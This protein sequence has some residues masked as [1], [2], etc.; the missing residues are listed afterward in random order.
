MNT[1]QAMRDGF[2]ELERRGELCECYGAY[3]NDGVLHPHY[4]EYHRKI[5][6]A[7]RIKFGYVKYERCFERECDALDRQ[8]IILHLMKREDTRAKVVKVGRFW[9]VLASWGVLRTDGWAA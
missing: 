5:A 8:H 1:D 2:R 6:M 9:V 4:C 3:D 7:E